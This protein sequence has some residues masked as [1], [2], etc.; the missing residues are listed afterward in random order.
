MI[1]AGRPYPCP[2]PVINHPLPRS[3]GE[4]DGGWGVTPQADAAEHRLQQQAAEVARRVAEAVERLALHEALAA[5]GEFVAQTNRYLEATAPWHLGA[6]DPRLGLVLDHAVEATR[7]AAWYYAPF[8]PRAATLAHCRLAGQPPAVGG[9]FRP[10]P[11]SVSPGPPLF[12]RPPAQD[13]GTR[14]NS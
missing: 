7:L 14:P 2:P 1:R 13:V 5:V 12:P 10:A 4:G 6:S 8:I 9:V 11:R 3:S